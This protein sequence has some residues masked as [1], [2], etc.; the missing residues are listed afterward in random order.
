MPRAFS[1][2]IL[3]R[4]VWAALLVACG[5]RGWLPGRRAEIAK[6]SDFGLMIM[7]VS[8]P[9]NFQQRSI[10][11]DL[12]EERQ[13]N[14]ALQKKIAVGHAA[15]GDEKIEQDKEIAEPKARADHGR[16]HDRVAQRPLAKTS[17]VFGSS[18]ALSGAGPSA[19]VA[20]LSSGSSAMLTIYMQRKPKPI[21]TLVALWLDRLLAVHFQAQF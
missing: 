20:S 10:A 11:R 16:V 14:R 4:R 3:A 5:G 17:A 2:R 19:A 9:F 12:T 6:K 18:E 13:L 7:R 21:Q 8:P 15:N 1:S